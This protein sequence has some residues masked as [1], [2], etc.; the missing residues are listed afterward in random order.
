VRRI[1]IAD[2]DALFSA[3]VQLKFMSEGYRVHAVENGRD[4]MDQLATCVPDLVL[5][6]L[7][8][9]GLS[10]VD[11]LERMREDPQLSSIPVLVVTSEGGSG[12]RARCLGLGAT[13]FY[14]K[15]VSLRT[16]A[17][18]VRSCLA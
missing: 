16:L 18:S 10:G 15:P 7:R 8:M 2:D 11:V 5:L 1:I 9:P 6:D 12:T 4:L 14:A 13:G 3:A 17:G